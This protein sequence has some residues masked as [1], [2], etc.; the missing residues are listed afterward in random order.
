MKTRD[1]GLISV[2]I[3]SQAQGL[4]NMVWRYC[5]D[6]FV[7]GNSFLGR[8]MVWWADFLWD[9]DL[10]VG[11]KAL[12]VQ[13]RD[14]GSKDYSKSE[15]WDSFLDYVQRCE[16]WAQTDPYVPELAWHP[17]N[18]KFSDC[19]PIW[20]QLG[21]KGDYFLVGVVRNGIYMAMA[22][23]LIDYNC[24]ETET[25]G[26]SHSI[27]AAKEANMALKCLD[28]STLKNEDEVVR[29]LDG[30]IKALDRI[31]YREVSPTCG[32]VEGLR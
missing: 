4:V 24:L 2:I 7:Y 29:R 5:Q 32:V 31:T 17:A 10:D 14:S 13:G 20:T 1:D 9:V 21:D 6:M 12:V 30:I 3:Q 16:R 8:N 11:A 25:H 15:N 18:L 28:L 19:V 27:T 23:M 22:D 26:L